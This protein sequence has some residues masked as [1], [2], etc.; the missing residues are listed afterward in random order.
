MVAGTRHVVLDVV[1]Y[2]GYLP[3]AAFVLLRKRR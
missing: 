3:S 2:C 1:G